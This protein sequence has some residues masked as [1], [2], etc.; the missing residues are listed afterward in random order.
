MMRFAILGLSALLAACASSSAAFL[1]IPGSDWQYSDPA[2][3]HWRY[4]SGEAPVLILA[5]KADY[6][7]PYRSPYSLAT[8]AT[9]EFENFE[10]TVE[11][12][13]TKAWYGHLDLCLIFA[14]RDAAH[15]AYAHLAEKADPNAHQIML[16]DD[17]PRRP[18]TTS[19]TQGV[20]W[21]EAW[22]RLRLV[23][24][25][26]SV[27][28]FFDGERVMAGTVPAGAGRVGVGSFDDTGEFRNLVVT[29]R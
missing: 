26:T 4:E 7:P 2:V 14:H 25:G 29:P 11:A 5:A 19:R 23:R 13:S 10:L 28:V 17:A 16:V 9:P 15:Y 6:K 20:S 27:E 1:A 22:H 12:R 21:G 24:E 18:V 3:W 8:L